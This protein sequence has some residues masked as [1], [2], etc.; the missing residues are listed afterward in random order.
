MSGARQH[1]DLVDT[2]QLADQAH[3][4]AECDSLTADQ[5]AELTSDIQVLDPT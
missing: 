4:L 1:Q 5:T 2:V 3:L